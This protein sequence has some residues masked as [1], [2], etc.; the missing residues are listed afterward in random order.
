MDVGCGVYAP[1]I[2]DLGNRLREVVT[3][4]PRLRNSRRKNVRYQSNR[5]LLGPSVNGL[6]VLEKGKISCPHRELNHPS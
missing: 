2:L 3:F 5:K 6:R 4:T 1:L